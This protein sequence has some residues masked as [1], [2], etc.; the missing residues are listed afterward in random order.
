MRSTTHEE[1]K[2]QLEVLYS[3]KEE[4]QSYLNGFCQDLQD[5]KNQVK[6]LEDRIPQVE[7]EIKKYD[8]AI[9]VLS[10]VFG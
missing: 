8:N 4:L 3:K 1:M 5:R 6:D 9:A 10:K 2:E 7:K